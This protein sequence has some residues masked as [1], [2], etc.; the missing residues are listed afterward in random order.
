MRVVGKPIKQNRQTVPRYTAQN[1]HAIL[2]LL[3]ISYVFI[4]KNEAQR[5]YKN[6]KKRRGAYSTNAKVV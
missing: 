3:K 4:T 1:H 2:A 5:F 6:Q